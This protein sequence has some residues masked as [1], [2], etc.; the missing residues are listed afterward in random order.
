M[1]VGGRSVSVFT[2]SQEIKINLDGGGAVILAGDL[3]SF[4]VISDYG[5]ISSWYI[6][7]TP[8]GSIVVDIWKATNAIPTAANS[9]VGSEPP[10]LI[11]GRLSSDTDLTTWSDRNVA[12]GDV[13]GCSITSISNL[14]NCVVT[15]KITKA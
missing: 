4:Y 12:P 5:Q 2:E 8:S 15:L 9:I 3:P 1:S 10:T 6:T 7:G 11:A 14:T 13:L